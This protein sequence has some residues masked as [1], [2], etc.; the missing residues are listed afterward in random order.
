MHFLSR[1]GEGLS[2]SS[3][4]EYSAYSKTSS[5]GSGC[6]MRSIGAGTSLASDS[7]SSIL[8]SL[9]C[10]SP[11]YSVSVSASLLPKFAYPAVDEPVSVTSHYHRPCFFPQ[12]HLR[13]PPHSVR[14]GTT[15]KFHSSHCDCP[16]PRRLPIL[17]SSWLSHSSSHLWP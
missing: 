11:S 15:G 10:A 8:Q 14:R 2:M 7:M 3:C 9:S 17:F 5:M 12:R 16:H 1:M 6:C 4:M 13:A